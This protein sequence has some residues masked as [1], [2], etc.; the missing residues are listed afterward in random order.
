VSCHGEG[1]R[2]ALLPN[3]PTLNGQNSAYLLQQMKDMKS[4]A[5]ANGQ[6]AVMKPFVLILNEEEMKQIS[7][8]LSK[9]K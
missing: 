9:Q 2:K 1:G 5:R 3:Y 4:G 7:D 8:Y 6:T